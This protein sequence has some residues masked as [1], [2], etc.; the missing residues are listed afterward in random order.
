MSAFKFPARR[1]LGFHDVTALSL[2]GAEVLLFE[3][4]VQRND[5]MKSKMAA[6][7]NLKADISSVYYYH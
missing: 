3:T 7:G 4:I 2:V 6:A 5:V 1:H